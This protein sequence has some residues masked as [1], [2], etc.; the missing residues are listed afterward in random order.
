MLQI[1]VFMVGS[2]PANADPPVRAETAS[3]QQEAISAPSLRA[4]YRQGNGDAPPVV[5]PCRRDVGSILE[6]AGML[7]SA[8]RPEQHEVRWSRR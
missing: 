7:S 2:L 5:P 1:L 4:R 3:S 6:L 8:L